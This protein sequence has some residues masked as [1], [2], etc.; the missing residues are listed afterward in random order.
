MYALSHMKITEMS[1]KYEKMIQYHCNKQP[2]MVMLMYA[3]LF[4]A[5][6]KKHRKWHKIAAEGQADVSI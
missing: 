3:M 2:A 4:Q 6:K 5:K 1:T